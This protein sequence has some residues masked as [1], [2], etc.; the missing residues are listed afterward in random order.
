MDQGDFYGT[1]RATHEGAPR[2]YQGGA[3]VGLDESRRRLEIRA[4]ARVGEGGGGGGQRGVHSQANLLRGNP[5]G[6]GEEE[7]DVTTALGK[8]SND[9]D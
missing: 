2:L 5:D 4:D 1:R 6:G 7:E 8:D 3:C 9:T